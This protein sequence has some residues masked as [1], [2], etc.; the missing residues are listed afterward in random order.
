[1]SPAPPKAPPRPACHPHRSGAASVPLQPPGLTVQ[2]G[3]VK[4]LMFSTT[5]IT[6]T[7]VFLQ[8]VSSRLTSPTDT[9]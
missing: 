4:P 7:P 2:C 8:K 3:Q 6:R 9:A 5:P 1:M